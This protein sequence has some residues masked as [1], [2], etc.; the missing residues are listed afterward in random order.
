[1]IQTE[2]FILDGGGCDTFPP[3]SS[4][5]HTPFPDS[6]STSRKNPFP[7]SSSTPVVT[8]N[9]ICDDPSDPNYW[10]ENLTTQKDSSLRT[11][12]NHPGIPINEFAE[13]L[14]ALEQENVALRHEIEDLKEVVAVALCFGIQSLSSITFANIRKFPAPSLMKLWAGHIHK[15]AQEH[16]VDPVGFNLS[17]DGFEVQRVQDAKDEEV[18]E[19]SQKITDE[20]SPENGVS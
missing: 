10:K 16:G 19:C 4:A 12:I 15:W 18:S 14:I 9:E 7:D 2:G 1:M 8:I 3:K 6:S 17:N 11:P 13:R 5:R 20:N